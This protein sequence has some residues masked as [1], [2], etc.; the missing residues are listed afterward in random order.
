MEASLFALND[1][2]ANALRSSPAST[3]WLAEVRGQLQAYRIYL[4]AHIAASEARDGVYADLL[5]T[6]PRVAPHVERL[7]ADCETM[8]RMADEALAAADATEPDA[9]GLR[10][11]TRDLVDATRQYASR[12][13]GVIHE[14]FAVDIGVG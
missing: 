14:A 1:R 9:V 2:L 5:D 12:R 6:E 10:R 4:D 11:R 7:R 3:A 13:V 8:R